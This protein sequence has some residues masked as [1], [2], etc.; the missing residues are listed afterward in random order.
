MLDKYTVFK[1]P[2][3]DF[4]LNTNLSTP[5]KRLTPMQSSPKYTIFKMCVQSF[6]FTI[7]LYM[8]IVFKIP[9]A[10]FFCLYTNLSTP[11]RRLTPMQS[12]PKYRA[13]GPGSGNITREITMQNYAKL[14]CRVTFLGQG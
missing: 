2:K 5:V 12:S 7:R 6:L 3:T 13:E 10:F 11:V 14:R 8:Y 1:I 9:R 4:C